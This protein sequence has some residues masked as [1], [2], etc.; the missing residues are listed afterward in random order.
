MRENIKG[1][2]VLRLTITANEQ[3]NGLAERLDWRCVNKRIRHSRDIRTDIPERGNEFPNGS[4]NK[5]MLIADS[6]FV[7]CRGDNH[8]SANM[9]ITAQIALRPRHR[10]GETM[11]LRTSN[12]VPVGSF[13]LLEMLC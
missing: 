7:G 9:R 12:D 8:S 13:N 2:L 3:V 4:S 10:T 11:K 5:E 1:N 6:G